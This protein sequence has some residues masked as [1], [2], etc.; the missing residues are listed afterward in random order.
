M[1]VS[2]YASGVLP[3]SGPAADAFTRLVMRLADRTPVV[4]VRSG[5]TLDDHVDLPMP[6]SAAVVDLAGTLDI[7]SNLA[8]QTAVIAGA[9]AFVSTYGGLSY[10]AVLL[11]VPSVGVFASPD[12]GVVHHRVA[13]AMVTALGG[14]ELTLASAQHLDLLAPAG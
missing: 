13:R 5:L 2:A 12:Y 11:G 1:A 8:A 14:A 4:L 9:E 6:R 3:A 10:L 7:A